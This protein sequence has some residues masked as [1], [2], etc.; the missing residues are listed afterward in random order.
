MTRRGKGLGR[1]N[2]EEEGRRYGLKPGKLMKRK[3]KKIEYN[4]GRALEE[5]KSGE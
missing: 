1:I 5:I 3:I 2:R 4:F